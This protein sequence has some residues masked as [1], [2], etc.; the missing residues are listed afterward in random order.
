MSGKCCVVTGGRGFAAR[1]LVD[2]LIRSDKFLVRIADLPPAIDLSP[3]E[4]NGDLGRALESGRASYVSM[5]LRNKPQVLQA[6]KGAEVVFHMAAP[7]SGIN[8]YQ[9]HYSV[10]VEGTKNVIDACVELKVK[11][12]IFTSSASV[13]FDGIHPIF[14][15]DESLPY[16]PKPLDSYSATKAEAEAAILKANGT[17]GLLTCSLRP[18]SI[19]G[20]GD[21]LFIPALAE[22]ARAGKSKFLI[23]DGNNVYDFTYVENVA[24]AHICAEQ[25][26]SSSGEAAE[27]AAGQAYFITNMEPIKFWEF[28]GN[29]CAGLGYERP[30]IKV[31]AI[32]VLPVA[33]A[34]QWAYNLLG[35][36]GMKLPVLIPSR[37][38]LLSGNR[39][40]SCAKAH[41]LLGYTPIVSLEDGLKRTIE[42]FSHLNA[43][44]Q[45]KREGE[46]KASLYLGNGKV[47]D[48]LLWKDTKKTLIVLLVLIGIYYS[49]ISSNTTIITATSKLLLMAAIFLFVHGRLPEKIF[50]YKIE[51]IHPSDFYWTEKKSYQVA[52][53]LASFWNAGINILES[54]CKGKD[55]LLFL[56]VVLSLLIIGFIGTISLHSLF[57]MGTLSFFY[58][59][60]YL[61]F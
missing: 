27:K 1:H 32:A 4:E 19:F 12:L 25:T 56:E 51:K 50:G 21:K 13:V 33:H 34:I 31:P 47:A 54:L 43:E 53:V 23:G 48:T 17:N 26:L 10:N 14:N 44:N 7:H 55:W 2:M 38:R 45:P 28:T 20:P 24:H 6:L 8:N 59:L 49:F 39:S 60:L 18:S 57:V 46:S 42:S 5:D 41:E 22:S 52:H 36:Y 58:Q 37:I 40:F 3:E 15:G 35:T 16:P 11:I 29:V 61:A 30:R 9:L